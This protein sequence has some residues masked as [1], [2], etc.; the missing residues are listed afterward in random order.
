MSTGC[1]AVTL[2]LPGGYL[3]FAVE[4]LEVAC[5]CGW[6]ATYVDDT[7]RLG[8]QN[9]VNHVVVHARAGRVGDDDIWPSV[10]RDEVVGED[11]LHVARIKQRVVDAVQ[12]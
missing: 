1:T 3:I 4:Q 2:Y 7:L 8:G 5:L 12:S 6:V 10:L 11:V 9:H